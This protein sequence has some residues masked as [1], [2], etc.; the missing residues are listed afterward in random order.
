MDDEIQQEQKPEAEQSQAKEM[1]DK[2]A[3]ATTKSVPKAPKPDTMI[4][5]SMLELENMSV[6]QL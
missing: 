4:S 6:S 1:D 3:K 5:P 2:L